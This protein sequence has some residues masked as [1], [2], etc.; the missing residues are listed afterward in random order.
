VLVR[1]IVRNARFRR[2]RR[3]LGIITASLE[4]GELSLDLIWF[5]ARNVPKSLKHAD[6]IAL[7]GVLRDGREGEIQL[8]NPEII[9]LST[10][11][12]GETPGIVPLYPDLGS[13]R[14]RTLRRIMAAAVPSIEGLE[15]Y[16]EEQDLRE[17][18]LPG[19]PDSLRWLHQPPREAEIGELEDGLS[20]AHWR[21]FFDAALFH[22]LEVEKIRAKRG[23][24]RA[25]Q[26]R[27]D[28][29]MRTSFRSLLPFVLTEAQERV[30]A[31]VLADIEK[32]RPMA[33]LLQGDVGSGKTA[34]AALAMA[35]AASSRCQAALMA[36]TEILAEQHARVLRSIFAE[37]P[38]RVVLLRGGLRAEPGQKARSAIREGDAEIIVGTHALIQERVKFE[39]LGL[40]VIDEQHR[41][42]TLQR[43]NLVLKGTTPHLLVMTATPIPR[44]LALSLY[45][46]L[47]LSLLDE[48]PKGR[49]PIQ[50]E[51]RTEQ[52]R[53]KIFSFLKREIEE[54]G[55]VYC[56]FPLIEL[57]EHF[58]APALMENLASFEKALPGIGI[59]VL[60][61]RMSSEE[62]DRV[63]AEFR[64]GDLQLL[65]STT[66]IEVGVDVPEAT[67]MVIEGAHRF[68]LSQLHQLRGRVGRGTRNSWCI[69]MIHD[70]LSER[71][72]RRLKIFA[73]TD[74]GFDLAEADLRMRGPG[75]LTGTRQWGAS[76][77]FDP[78][79]N[80]DLVLKSRRFAENLEASSRADTVMEQLGEYYGTRHDQDDWRVM[81]G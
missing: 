52:A 71:A 4:D 22:F 53:E 56:V 77:P 48:K 31:E 32:P 26:I 43:S 59:G 18:G 62:K 55:R 47:D 24:L 34:V 75:E 49:P 45:G 12:N 80:W 64:C 60:H 76:L 40:V 11:S 29:E 2:L 6:E 1:G 50:T 66:V 30:F 27:C 17:L 44:S 16:L 54:G 21:L 33:R 19:L 73:S 38:W 10:V 36:P 7:C 28:S 46:D 14:G 25:P 81:T 51:I 70:Q 42:G 72:R 41:F 39:R 65:M 63:Q 15:D 35:A 37:T 61:G 13:L 69:V 67:V 9:E 58:D 79:K 68:G 5:N 57:S 8:V 3:G 20:P 74:D 23:G 78:E